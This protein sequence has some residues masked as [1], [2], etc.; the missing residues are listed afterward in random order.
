M[1]VSNFAAQLPLDNN[2]VILRLPAI[3]AGGSTAVTGTLTFGI[4]TQADNALGSATVLTA[5]A[6]GS[7][8]TVFN[9]QSLPDSFIDSGSNGLYFT[10][11]AISACSGS[12]NA[13]SF[14][15][16]ASTLSFSATN[17]GQNGN[18]SNVQFQIADLQTISNANF[19]I[20]DVG[21]T[22]AS[23]S[24]LGSG[25]FDWGLPFFYGRA[26]YIAIEN[27]SAAGTVGPYYAY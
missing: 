8:T 25:Y 22:A 12:G 2:G 5:N 24:G 15:C 10:D 18:S 14:Y 4:A 9:G 7:I 20:D 11:H 27:A 19:A 26:V 17:T 13:S 6:Q 1:Q 16:P 3:A 23:I 21:G